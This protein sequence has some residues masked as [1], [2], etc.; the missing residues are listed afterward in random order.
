MSDEHGMSGDQIERVFGALGRIEE[1]IDNHTSWMERHVKDDEG[2]E[3]RVGEL[4][5]R[6]ARQKG[7]LGALAGVG[8]VIGAGVGY[9]AE[10][11]HRG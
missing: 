11:F 10:Y 8:G 5:L 3:K 7:F 9:L 4:E 2:V 6:A 1:K